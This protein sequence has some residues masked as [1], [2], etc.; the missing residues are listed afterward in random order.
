P[1]YAALVPT[2]GSGI[3]YIVNIVRR[4][5]TAAELAQNSLT[6]KSDHIWEPEKSNSGLRMFLSDVVAGDTALIGL[7]DG[8]FKKIPHLMPSHEI[9]FLLGPI[10]EYLETNKNQVRR[11][12][13]YSLICLMQFGN[14]QEKTADLRLFGKLLEAYCD[15]GIDVHTETRL[16]LGLACDFES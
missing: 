12:A 16:A 15:V 8:L 13:A 5:F 7:R 2:P 4:D 11:T 1:V 9:T 10:Q 14:P 6:L 3:V